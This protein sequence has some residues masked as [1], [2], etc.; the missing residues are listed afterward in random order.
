MASEEKDDLDRLLHNLKGAASN[1]GFDDVALMAQGFRSRTISEDDL[2]ALK[3]AV[4]NQRPKL[5]A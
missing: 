2:T 5:A 3:A 4:D 1:L